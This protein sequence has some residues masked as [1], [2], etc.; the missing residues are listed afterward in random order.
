MGGL[1]IKCHYT[2][3]FEEQCG[4]TIFY[5]NLVSACYKCLKIYAS[6]MQIVPYTQL[7]QTPLW[8][9]SLSTIFY[10]CF[11]C[12]KTYAVNDVESDICLTLLKCAVQQPLFQLPSSF[13]KLEWRQI[14]AGHMRKVSYIKSVKQ[15]RWNHPSTILW[16]V[17]IRSV[18]KHMHVL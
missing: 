11:N 7:C 17:Y 2:P 18:W 4:D 14:F 5:N 1:Q 3:C 10:H 9:I 8:G 6:P 16:F 15:N 13:P 12:F